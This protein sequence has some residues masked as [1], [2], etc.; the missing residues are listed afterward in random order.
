MTAANA[1]I[2]F[3]GEAD[4]RPWL[5]GVHAGLERVRLETVLF[6]RALSAPLYPEITEAD[7]IAAFTASREVA[8]SYIGAPPS[9]AC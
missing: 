1:V 9:M 4:L 8:L 7:W 6:G 3:G 2:T 5:D